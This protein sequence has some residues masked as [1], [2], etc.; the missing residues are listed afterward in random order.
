M[1]ASVFF[2]IKEAIYAARYAQHAPQRC[3]VS[4]HSHVAC[5]RALASRLA[6]SAEAGVTGHFT[7]DAPA[8][9]ERIR[10]SCADAITAR[11]LGGLEAAAA[12][13]AKG[14]Y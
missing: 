11:R 2:A 3:V 1:A 8:T 5:G 9:A 13:R 10:M 7:L 14:S 12:Y 6:C 4:C